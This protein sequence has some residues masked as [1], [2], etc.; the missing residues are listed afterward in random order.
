MSTMDRLIDTEELAKALGISSR[1][2]DTWRT[3]GEGPDYIKIGA[4][5]RYRETD[6]EQWLSTVRVIQGNT[7]GRLK[8]GPGWADFVAKTVQ[9]SD[10]SIDRHNLWRVWNEYLELHP[11]AR[12]GS[13][14]PQLESDLR[15]ALS[16]L[17][18]TVDASSTKNVLAGIRL[19]TYGQSLLT[20]IK[21]REWNLPGYVDAADVGAGLAG[22][23]FA[24]GRRGND[25]P[26]D[27]VIDF[28]QH[29]V[30]AVFGHGT[31]KTTAVR[32]LI[33]EI[34]D[35]RRTGDLK[36]V[37]A[38]HDPRSSLHPSST[39]HL[40]LAEDKYE[41]DFKL[42]STTWFKAIEKII[43]D[44]TPPTSEWTDVNTPTW[45]GETIYLIVDNLDWGVDAATSTVDQLAHQKFG[46]SLVTL[47]RR[48]VGLRIILTY[49]RSFDDQSLRLNSGL[50]LDAIADL[51]NIVTLGDNTYRTDRTDKLIGSYN[52]DLALPPGAGYLNSPREP[53]NSGYLQLAHP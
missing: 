36:A 6:I 50:K 33:R 15:H 49:D 27:V 42:F 19:T 53:W 52:P 41:H 51:V 46:Q 40:D 31:G 28:A 44:R 38:V 4:Q 7:A 39:R 12:G 35:R 18:V 9:P 25:N 8:P 13:D 23:Q 22:E 48:N 1:T 29:P 14:N 34:T 45:D 10:A 2:V 37:L 3:A 16:E 11:D 26:T 30:L 24:I 47:A 17:S 5:V 32:H 21:S 43:D 20:T